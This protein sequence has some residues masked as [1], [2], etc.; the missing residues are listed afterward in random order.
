MIKM[1]FY[2]TMPAFY[3]ERKRWPFVGKWMFSHSFMGPWREKKISKLIR[4]GLIQIVGIWSPCIW[5]MRKSCKNWWVP[6]EGW[7][8]SLPARPCTAETVDR[9]PAPQWKYFI[10]RSSFSYGFISTHRVFEARGEGGV[11]RKKHACIWIKYIFGRTSK[12]TEQSHGWFCL[13]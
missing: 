7:L 8:C 3:F 4:K 1:F 6:I 10:D 13:N 9:I 2:S 12:W 5:C 11:A